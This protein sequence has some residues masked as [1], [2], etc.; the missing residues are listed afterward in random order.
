MNKIYVLQKDLPD[1]KAGTELVFDGKDS[2][3]YKEVYDYKD[4]YDY[5]DGY[6]YEDKY[7]Y[8]DNYE[9]IVVKFEHA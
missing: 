1:A 2:Y 7:E 4:G 6:N 5:E 8:K 3:D 9:S